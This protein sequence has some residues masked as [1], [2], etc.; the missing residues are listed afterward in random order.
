MRVAFEL[1]PGLISDETLYSTPG[2]W[3]DGNGVRFR[4]GKPETNG[5]YTTYNATDLTGVCRNI[6]PW[7]D[8]YLKS[9]V[10]FGTHS[11]LM[12]EKE[13]TLYDITPSGLPTGEIDSATLGGGWGSGGWGMGGW[14]IGQLEAIARTWS[15]ATY[16]QVLFG[17]PRGFPIYIWENDTAVAAT[18]LTQGPDVNN[19][20]LVP[21]DTQQIRSFGC[22]EVISGVYNP[23]C[24]RGSDAQNYLDWTPN[25]SDTGFEVIIEGGSPIIGARVYGDRDAIWTEKGCHLG[26]FVGGQQKYRVDWIDGPGLLGPNA[27]CVINRV[28][29]WMTPDLR[30][31]AW[32]YGASPVE[33]PCP[34]SRDFR[35]NLTMAQVGKIICTPIQRFNEVRWYYPDARDGDGLENSRYITYE[36]GESAIAGLPV[37]DR[38]IMN[39]TAAHDDGTLI[40]PLMVD[41]DGNSYLHEYGKSANGGAL[42][43]SITSSAQYLDK[44]ERYAMIRS[45]WPDIESQ[46]GSVSL[47]LYG[48]E[49]P[50]D[51]ASETFGPFTLAVNDNK[52]DFMAQS[53]LL[54]VKYSGSAASTFARIGS[55]AFDVVATGKY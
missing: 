29:Y 16:G 54:T 35:D 25:T 50:Q 9:N 13:G 12:V 7:S 51:S 34:I 36:I 28:A 52:Y 14:G 10:A 15:F 30:F 24:I 11:K 19:C 6:L 43:W 20:I 49:W 45:I 48:Y 2:R 8:L 42:S 40:Y 27:A 41:E 23:C 4:F 33:I 46:T 31:F 26:T 3:E 44:G 53:R 22:N 17:V 1:A 55:P 39:R 37:W 21:P 38:G 18:E 5:G 32:P 47:T